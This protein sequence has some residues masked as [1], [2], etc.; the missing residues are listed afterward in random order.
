[1][2]APFSPNYVTTKRVEAY[3]I[4]AVG[5][6]SVLVERPDGGRRS[7]AVPAGFM[8]RPPSVGDMLV[9]YSDGYLSHCPRDAFERDARPLDESVITRTDELPRVP[10]HPPCDSGDPRLPPGRHH[11]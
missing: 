11:P 6:A 9:G 2:S 10:R 4:V 1:M 7:V 3:Q 5:P 8:A